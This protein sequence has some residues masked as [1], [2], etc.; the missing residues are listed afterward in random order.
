MTQNDGLRDRSGA[1]ESSDPLVAF[2]YHL[3]RDHLPAGVVE[4]IV[5]NHVPNPGRE[6]TAYF[7]NGYLASYAK[8]IAARLKEPARD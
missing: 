5:Q 1:V 6:V 7:T 2:L 8:D 3:M 4:G